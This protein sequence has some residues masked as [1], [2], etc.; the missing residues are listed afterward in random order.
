MA[1]IVCVHNIHGGNLSYSGWCMHCIYSA[2]RL[3]LNIYIR[4]LTKEQRKYKL[5]RG[6]TFHTRVLNANQSFDQYI[7]LI[8]S[9]SNDM[10]ME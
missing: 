2:C 7:N 5:Q 9:V 6:L 10:K 3:L 8:R 1:I 4:L